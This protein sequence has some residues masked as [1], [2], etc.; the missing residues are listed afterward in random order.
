MIDPRQANKAAY[1]KYCDTFRIN[2]SGGLFTA[3][4][5]FHSESAAIH[6]TAPINFVNGFAGLYEALYKPLL[7]AMP[8]LYRRTELLFSG[9][10]KGGDWVTGHGH[11]VGTFKKDWMGIPATGQIVF[12]RFGEFH[13]M[14]DGRALESYLFF[15]IID[16]MRQIDRWPLPVPSVGEEFFIPGPITCD[17]IVMAPQDDAESKKSVNMV[18]DML[19]CLYTKDEAWRPYWHENMMW[20]GPAGYGS[21]IGIDGF[22]RFQMPYESVFDPRRK[23][24]TGL[25]GEPGSDLDKAVKG[26]FTRFAEGNYVASGGWPSHGSYLTKDWLGVKASGQLFAVRVA[27]WWRR[28]GDLLVENWV[29]VD[30]IDMLLQLDY[31]VFEAVDIKLDL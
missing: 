1:K 27:D 28:E 2:A 19:K 24:E 15:D 4:K 5:E 29:F 26:H 6:V 11:L 10:A 23:G 22:A 20:Y 14:E 8:D 13:R 17:G 21:Y 9:N 3:C 30:L 16:L 25:T 31:D 7:Y 12:I 18:F